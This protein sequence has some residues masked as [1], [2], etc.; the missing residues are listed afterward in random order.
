MDECK[1][2]SVDD[3]DEDPL[4]GGLNIYLIRVPGVEGSGGPK[5]PLSRVLAC[6]SKL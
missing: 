6:W 5:I 4:L 1:G 2:K 3:V